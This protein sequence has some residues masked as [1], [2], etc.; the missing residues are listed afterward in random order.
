[1][2]ERSLPTAQ[3]GSRDYRLFGL[4]LRSAIPLPELDESPRSAGE[5]VEIGWG[6]VPV[7]A[8]E[9]G[10]LGALEA[11]P[12]GAVL[13]VAG[14]ARFLVR[15]GCSIRVDPDP[16]ASERNVRLYLLGSA[17]GLLLHQ[18]R[19]LPLHANAIDIDGRAI[20]FMGRSGEGKSTLAAAFHDR[21]R[22]ILSDDVCAVTRGDAGFIAQPGIPRLRLWR[23]AVERS[24]RVTDGHERAFDALDKYTV[25]TDRAARSDALPLRA[26]YLLSRQEE[27]D[28]HIR[29]LSVA[30]AFQ[31][32]SENTYRGAFVRIVGDPRAHFDACVALSREVPVF[33]FVRPW[34]AARIE[35]TTGRIE[36]HLRSLG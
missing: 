24:G 20:A 3:P 25:Q 7:I 29:P 2:A 4:A 21:G 17:M 27:A 12:R 35:E 22:R 23:D 26:V 11:T 10:A 19:I 33:E 6:E 14:I 31:A 13:Q 34:D 5:A 8:A 9:G 16:A 15:D 36:D 30:Q 18:R 32:L 28:F 1:M